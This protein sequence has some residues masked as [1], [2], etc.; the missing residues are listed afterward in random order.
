MSQPSGTTTGGTFRFVVEKRDGT[1]VREFERPHFSSN[2][3]G[4]LVEFCGHAKHLNECSLAKNWSDFKISL[5]Y[6]NDGQIHDAGKLPSDEQIE[7]FLMRLRPIYLNDST[8]NFDRL[9]KAVATY[10]VDPI[11]KEY[12]RAWKDIYTAKHSQG[13]FTIKIGDKIL[14]S[15]EFF[16]AYVNA[17]A[18]HKSDTKP[19]HKNYIN[20]VS[21]AFPLEA[22][23]PLFVLLLGY[24]LNGI[25]KFTQ[26][27]LTCFDREK[28][29][30][31]IRLVE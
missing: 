10:L 30:D 28:N 12:S 7:A 3:K 21:Q 14:N 18:F 23:K 2:L 25:A 27:L 17:L 5:H 22:Q 13:A 31:P 20:D 26:F 11:F 24:R 8:T 9:T 19:R 15:T 1:F 16:D 29:G 4:P 6:A